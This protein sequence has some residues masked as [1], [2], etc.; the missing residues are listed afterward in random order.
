MLVSIGIEDGLSVQIEVEDSYSPD[1]LDDVC[2]RARDAFR[3]S[4][5]DMQHTEHKAE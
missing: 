1:L 3:L 5:A 4:Y 2:N